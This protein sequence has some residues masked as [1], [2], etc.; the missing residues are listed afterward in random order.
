MAKIADYFISAVQ[1]DFEHVKILN[2]KRHLDRG[3][4]VA[5]GNIVNRNIIYDDLK[6][7]LKYQTIRRDENNKWVIG[8][9]ILL[10]PK[11]GIITIDPKNSSSDNLGNLPEF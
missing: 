9:D 5:R 11:T 7:G 2:V 1:Y 4:F 8:K 10:N 3:E 6:K